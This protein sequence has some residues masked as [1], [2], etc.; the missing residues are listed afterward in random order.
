MRTNK[1]LRIASVLL[2]AVLMTTCIIGGTFAKY[3]SSV[4]TA[5]AVASVATWSVTVNDEDITADTV[6]EISVDIA[7][8]VYEN[9]DGTNA[10]DEVATGVIAPGTKGS[11]AFEVENASQVAAVVTVKIDVTS[12]PDA[13]N[14]VGGTT[15]SADGKDY[16]TFTTATLAHTDG[17]ATV[18][19]E[20]NWDFGEDVD[21]TDF[22]GTS[23]TLPVTITA[24]QVD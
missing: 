19:V 8:T 2:I 18:T 22:A 9:E 14:I 7:S 12:L 10:D 4:S 16:V 6:E 5:K 15:S 20:W 1:T 23:L 13:I 17:T 21:D 11:F 3:T 24:D